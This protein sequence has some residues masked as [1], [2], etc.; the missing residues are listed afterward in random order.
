MGEDGMRVMSVRIIEWWGGW[1][2]NVCLRPWHLKKKKQHQ[3][4][5]KVEWNAVK[6]GE[7]EYEKVLTSSQKCL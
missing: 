6:E 4:Q 2:G 1:M 7:K 3:F 5:L